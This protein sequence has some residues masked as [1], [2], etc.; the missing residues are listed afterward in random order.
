MKIIRYATILLLVFSIVFTA[1]F[2]RYK[3]SEGKEIGTP[4]E[5]KGII[6]MWNVDT[7]EGGVGSRKQFLLRVARGFEKENDGVLVM[8]TD[9]TTNSV[10]ENFKNGLYPD[11]ISYGNGTC[12]ENVVELDKSVAI[13]GGTVGGKNY[14][15]AWCR[16]G[17]VL[18][19]NPKLTDNIPDQID[20]LLVSQSDYT[21][22]LAALC[23]E[24]IVVKEVS[25]LPPMD[26][27]IK[28]VE[29][30]TPYFLGT[31]RD[32]NRLER[33]GVEIISRPLQ[34]YN[35]LYQYLS[36]TGKDTTKGV[37]AERFVSYLLSESVQ[38]SLTSIG[39]LSCKYSVEYDN[40][41]LSNMQKIVD[42]STVSA[43]TPSEMLIKMQELSLRAIKGDEESKIKIKNMLV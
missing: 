10:K 32:L 11:I 6:T 30:K 42:F 25:V 1:F 2:G 8:V 9:H 41:H 34:N 4:S 29:G 28:F 40:E 3:I 38:K 17:Y 27:Y 18:I 36:V 16:G 26:A 5:Y 43:F 39:M 37:Y 12:I 31:Q 20:T 7:F 14:A 15:A 19:A 33:R 21:Q 24:G 13:K 22:P 35:D 23:L